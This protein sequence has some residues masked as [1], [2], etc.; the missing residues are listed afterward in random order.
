[1][2]GVELGAALGSPYIPFLTSDLE[3]GLLLSSIFKRIKYE[4]QLLA[5]CVTVIV[6]L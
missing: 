6:S 1:M 5:C 2:N 3:Y 4:L